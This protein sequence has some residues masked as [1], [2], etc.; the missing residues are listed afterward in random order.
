VREMDGRRA[1]ERWMLDVKPRAAA[2]RM[3]N[4][5]PDSHRACGGQKH[6]ASN[7]QRLTFNGDA[8]G[9]TARFR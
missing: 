8:N 5:R 9:V 7:V 6:P 4:A 3:M 1:V 2:P